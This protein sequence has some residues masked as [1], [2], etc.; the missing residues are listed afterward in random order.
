MTTITQPPKKP[1]LSAPPRQAP[2]PVT[3]TAAKPATTALAKTVSKAMTTYQ[4]PDKE[5]LR[6]ERQKI[7]DERA[8]A[9]SSQNRMKL[10]EGKNVIRIL[11]GV[12]PNP[13]HV[14]WVH[15]LR[16]PANPGKQGRPVVCPLKTRGAAC[17][18][19]QKVSQL[20]RSGTDID[21]SVAS[22]I[23]SARRILCNAIDI[24]AP[25]KGVRALEFGVKLYD[26][27]LTLLVGDEENAEEF[28]GLD[29]TDP[30]NGFNIL[31]EKEVGDKGNTKET[32]RY[33]APKTSTKP[34]AV[35]VKDWMTKRHD[36]TKVYETVDD[37]RIRA[38]MEGTEDEAAQEPEQAQQAA[39]SVEDDMGA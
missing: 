34:T 1:V 38:I 28:P 7:K 22:D 30:V 17:I 24:G 23:R 32:T 16:N 26:E 14:T 25:D 15:Y 10:E 39:G 27:L 19:C 33:S 3:A 36:L 5:A 21:K 8:A 12:G 6:K 2:R 31:I 11:P 9:R 37:D 13:F 29:Y 4:A 20:N 18:V 35:S